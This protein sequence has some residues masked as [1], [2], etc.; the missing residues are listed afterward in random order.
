MFFASLCCAVVVGVFSSFAILLL[1][2]RELV[3]FFAVCDLCSVSLPHGAVY[4]S[5]VCDC[6]ICLVLVLWY[7]SMY[8]GNDLA[9][10]TGSSTNCIPGFIGRVFRL[11]DLSIDE[12]VGA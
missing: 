3:A 5:V 9:Q 4:W 1:T 6:G 11:K 12:M 10:R 8:F 7:S 2:K